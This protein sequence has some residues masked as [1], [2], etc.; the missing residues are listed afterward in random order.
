MPSNTHSQG[1]NV[2]LSQMTRREALRSRLKGVTP[3]STRQRNGLRIPESIHDDNVREVRDD[4]DS[5][6]EEDNQ[7]RHGEVAEGS[8]R[9][10]DGIE[11]NS[12]DVSSLLKEYVSCRWIRDRENETK[13]LL[14]ETG[15][16]AAFQT[17]YIFNQK[18]IDDKVL[19]GRVI[20]NSK[21]CFYSNFWKLFF[22]DGWDWTLDVSIGNK[23]IAN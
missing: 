22:E 5:S 18:K 16:K 12:L 6:D 23:Q 8:N 2:P 13:A 1:H 3:D 17:F 11:V 21:K 19:T 20:H 9:G 10:S 15:G 4:W 14:I 7:W